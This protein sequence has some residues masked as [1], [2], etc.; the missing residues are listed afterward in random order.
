M[1][2]LIIFFLFKIKYKTIVL[3]DFFFFD[4]KQY[5]IYDLSSKTAF[6]KI[7]DEFPHNFEKI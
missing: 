4:K 7:Y 2:Q 5:H 6:D 1:Q 3:L